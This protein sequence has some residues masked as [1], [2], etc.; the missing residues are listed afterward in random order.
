[1]N[2]NEI[3]LFAGAAVLLLLCLPLAGTRKLILEL[4][5][6]IVRLSLI[7]LLIAGAGLWLRPDLLPEQVVKTVGA[8]PEL[9]SILPSPESRT[10]GLAV[11]CLAAA[12]LLPCL[13]MLDVTRRLAGQRLRRLRAL[14]NPMPVLVP[15][16]Q[17]PAAVV[18]PAPSLRRPDRRAAAEVVARAGSRSPHR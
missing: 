11:A 3:L 1:M 4:S 9:R 16:A 2:T 17:A 12:T 6:W 14:S 18:E 7:A 5:A 8:S 13:A 10:Y 15:T